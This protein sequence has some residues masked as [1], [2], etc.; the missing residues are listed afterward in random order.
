[1]W[2]L[3]PKTII[4]R[5]GRLQNRWIVCSSGYYE[6]TEL[7]ELLTSEMVNTSS[8]WPSGG[9]GVYTQW[10]HKTRENKWKLS[11][12]ILKLEKTKNNLFMWTETESFDFDGSIPPPL[13]SHSIRFDFDR[14]TKIRLRV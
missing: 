9:E 7:L 4:I 11:L 2:K 14:Q 8:A 6:V 1:M 13:L 12:L 5:D 10:T 3:D